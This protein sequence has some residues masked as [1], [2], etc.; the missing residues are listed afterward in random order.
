MGGC[1]GFEW[2]DEKDRWNRLKHGVA[3]KYAIRAFRDPE[4]LTRRDV[5]HSMTEERFYCVGLVDGE[6][7]T[8]RFTHRGDAMRIIGAG[9]WRK[10]RRLYEEKNKIHG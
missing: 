4:R 3:F 1:D 5:R 9:Y 6:V 8:V 10:G 7:L 2:D